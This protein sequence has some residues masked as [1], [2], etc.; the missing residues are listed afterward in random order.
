MTGRRIRNTGRMRKS[1]K[2]FYSIK[3][4]EGSQDPRM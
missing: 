4:D 2:R 3:S 1:R